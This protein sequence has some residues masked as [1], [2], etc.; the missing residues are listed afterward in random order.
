MK[1]TQ[2]CTEKRWLQLYFLMR[3]TIKLLNLIL[4][5]SWTRCME[6]SRVESMVAQ[7]Q[8]AKLTWI[9][10][11][12]FS[13]WWF[14]LNEDITVKLMQ[15]FSRLLDCSRCTECVGKKQEWTYQVAY[16]CVSQILT[17]AE[18]V[19]EM[20]DQLGPRTNI[21]HSNMD[22]V[23]YL[24]HWLFILW[25][26]LLSG[27]VKRD[28]VVEDVKAMRMI[29]SQ[30]ICPGMWPSAWCR[31]WGQKHRPM[32]TQVD[33]PQYRCWSWLTLHL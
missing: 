17:M 16:C 7:L 25:W 11:Y 29:L 3:D 21:W 6:R 31:S 13:R 2:T 8:P 20:E 19:R 23:E 5:S 18:I 24:K 10:K 9:C 30:G 14:E 32:Q 22:S 28:E 27:V 26:W 12:V 4:V 1:I 15:K 33:L